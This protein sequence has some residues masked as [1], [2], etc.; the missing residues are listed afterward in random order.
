M[1]KLER[2]LKSKKHVIDKIVIEETDYEMLKKYAKA[3]RKYAVG[4]GFTI[5]RA[6][7]QAISIGIDA[8][9]ETQFVDEEGH[10]IDW[11]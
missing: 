8:I 3:M 2:P 10:E 7:Q 6:V 9:R 5:D 4:K 1:T 11:S